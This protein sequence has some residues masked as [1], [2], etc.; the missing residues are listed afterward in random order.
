MNTIKISEEI[1]W[2]K[3]IDQIINMAGPWVGDLI[4]GN[5]SIIDNVLIDNIVYCPECHK[6][7]FVRYNKIS[8]WQN[9][10]YFT[11]TSD[12]LIFRIIV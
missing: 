9:D 6:L 8:K 10:N 4:I 1:V 2:F 12:A 5:T 3:N 11:I 7:L